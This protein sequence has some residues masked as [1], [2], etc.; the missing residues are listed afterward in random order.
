MFFADIGLERNLEKSATNCTTLANKETILDGID[1][2]QYLG[3]LENKSNKIMKNEMIEKISAEIKARI[4]RLTS[5]KLNAV[6]LFKALNEH[7]LSLYNYYIGLI[8]IEPDDF[9]VID[10]EIRL[11]L[12]S[13]HIHLRPAN[14][15]RLYLP[16]TYL[17][18]GLESISMK[19]ERMLLE[20]YTDIK[21]KSV[22][23]LSE[24]GW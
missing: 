4:K 11:Q 23:C 17:G 10:R 24:K 7:A 22:C 3:V 12:N 8:D 9:E 21:R 19:S 2:Y 6:N 1:G 15:Q 14:C 20:F 16:R 5:T 18:R 13:Y